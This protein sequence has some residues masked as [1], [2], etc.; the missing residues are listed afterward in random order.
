MKWVG[1]NNQVVDTSQDSLDKHILDGVMKVTQLK[2]S[3]IRLDN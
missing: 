2:L 3:W 1:V